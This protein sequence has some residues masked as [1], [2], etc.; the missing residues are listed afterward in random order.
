[1]RLQ[2]EAAAVLLAVIAPFAAWT[3]ALSI[4]VGPG[5]DQAGAYLPASPGTALPSTSEFHLEPEDGEWLRFSPAFIRIRLENASLGLVPEESTFTLDGGKRTF[6]WNPSSRTVEALL[7]E[8]LEDG[9]HVVEV[10]LVHDSPMVTKLAWNFGLDTEVPNVELEPLPAVASDPTLEIRGRVSDSWLAGVKVQGQEVLLEDG[11]FSVTVPLWPAR[12]DIVVEAD[13]RAGNLRRV[14]RVVELQT[15]PFEGLMETR[16]L[17]NASFAID[18]PT[19][20]AAQPG[21][22][23]PSG[24]QADLMALAPFQPGLLTTVTVLSEPTVLTFSSPRASEWMRLVLAAVESSG[25]L[26]QVVSGPLLLEDPPGTVAVRS[27]FLRQTA[28]DQIAFVQLTMVWSQLVRRQW[29]LIASADES[30]AGEMWPALDAIISSFRVLDEGL[31]VPENPEAAFLLPTVFVASA[32]VV[33]V[34]ILTVVLLP[35]YLRRRKQKKEGQ[36]RPPRN[37][38]L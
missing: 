10:S 24:N 5:P 30:Q 15:P 20:W 7:P 32:I 29:V 4:P 36:W 21:I 35:V 33:L 19:G 26:K 3:L 38:R 27:T 31:G 11:N 25:E 2:V 37:W 34:G 23:L 6:A 28:S 17:E 12:N 8:E 1:M 22:L 18:V 9:I 13:D 14:V 16:I